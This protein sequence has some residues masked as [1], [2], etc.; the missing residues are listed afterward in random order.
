MWFLLVNM[1]FLLALAALLGAALAWWWFRRNFVDVTESHT[2]LT[3]QVETFVQ[4]GR[5]LTR[6]D[7]EYS[8]SQA[9]TAYQP[10]QPNLN[11][12]HE[13]LLSLEGV[14]AAPDQDVEALHRRMATLEQAVSAMSASIATIRTVNLDSLDQNL[15]GLGARLDNL[16]QPDLD[17]I[18]VQLAGIEDRLGQVRQLIADQPPA[19][20]D[21]GPIHSGL[22]RIDLSLSDLDIPEVDLEP[23]QRQLAALE[24][25]L[26]DLPPAGEIARLAR[27]L[28]ELR[29]EILSAPGHEPIFE[30]LSLL[31]EA[32]TD[33][34]APLPAAL[35][36]VSEKL[37]A[38]E[39]QVHGQRSGHDMLRAALA[40]LE[41]DLDAILRRVTDFNAIEDRLGHLDSSLAALR[42]DPRDRMQL[43]GIE[44]R[45]AALQE[46][47]RIPPHIDLSALEDRLTAIEYGLSAAH[48]MLRSRGDGS[49][50]E[51][52]PPPRPRVP[53]YEAREARP[54]PQ[55]V[56]K[57]EPATGNAGASDPVTVAL[58]EDRK[59]S[60]LTHAAFG[61]GD[62]LR[63]IVGIGPMLTDL[64]HSIGVYYFWQIAGWTEDDVNYVDDLLQHFR[65]RITR[66]DWVGQAQVLM[67]Q[68]GSSG[69]P[70]S[71]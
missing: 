39:Q 63:R 19:E 54:P 44:R 14:L 57:A 1:L 48:H 5:A 50:L 64:L 68:P 61:E 52:P 30:R 49:A 11:P 18:A 36:S 22:A 12:L 35:G 62:D 60:L 43:E 67:D 31:Q 28:D 2:E 3:R 8:L 4:Q 65:G 55:R 13:R 58:R 33:L 42:A 10:P 59:A 37:S 15:S 53:A 56:V 70:A 40:G 38:L 7:V 27:Q 26:G 45:I 9:L 47:V 24:A 6:D 51:L 32:V 21:L 17:P 29:E 46:M 69:R 34:D 16:P 25:R 66:D 23:V 20:I 41:S 71:G